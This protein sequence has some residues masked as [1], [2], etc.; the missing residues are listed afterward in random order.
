MILVTNT[1]VN[2]SINITKMKPEPGIDV[3]RLR[4][5]SGRNLAGIRLFTS[6]KKNL[7][8]MIVKASG[9]QNKSPEIR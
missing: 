9:I 2:R 5:D 6:S 1:P 3:S 8:T 7:I 4:S